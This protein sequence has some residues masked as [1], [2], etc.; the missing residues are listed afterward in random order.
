ML[1]TCLSELEEER[2]R[3]ERVKR[4]TPILVILGNPAYNGYAGMACR[5]VD[6]PK[7]FR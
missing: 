5:F 1:R 3:A 2:D 7:I 6:C 4:D